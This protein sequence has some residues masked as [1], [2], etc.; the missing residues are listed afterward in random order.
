MLIIC[1]KLIGIFIYRIKV[2]AKLFFDLAN[3]A[4]FLLKLHQA[5]SKLSGSNVKLVPFIVDISKYLSKYPTILEDFDRII[6]ND[7]FE[8]SV[9]H[10]I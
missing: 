8:P 7:L 5:L 10:I 1:R 3:F 9:D 6:K 2:I 4:V